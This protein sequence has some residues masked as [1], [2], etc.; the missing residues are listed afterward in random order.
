MTV[1]AVHKDTENLTMTLIAEFEASQER[2]WELWSDPRQLE[3]W[4]GPPTFP[5]TFTAFD[6]SPGGVMEYHMTGP[7]GEQPKAYW[8]IISVDPPHSLTFSD[9]FRNDDGSRNHDFPE[10]QVVVAIEDIGEGRTQMSIA[11][12]FATADAMEQLLTMG[13]EEGLTSAVGQIDGILA[14]DSARSNA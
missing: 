2:V 6:M 10:M 11:S 1:T 3:R 5:A 14:E 12:Q 9:G 4:W 8:E 13:M 7:E